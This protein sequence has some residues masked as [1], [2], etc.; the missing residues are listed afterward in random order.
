MKLR[1]QTDSAISI[2]NFLYVGIIVNIGENQQVTT[3][4]NQ[5]SEQKLSSNKEFHQRAELKHRDSS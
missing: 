3:S 4:I 1:M 2:N 5:H